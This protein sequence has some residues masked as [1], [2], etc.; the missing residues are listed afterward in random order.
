[1]K[2]SKLLAMGTMAL[3]VASLASAATNIKITGSTAFRTATIAAIIDSL[4]TT[5]HTVTGGYDV[6]AK[7]IAGS[8]REIIHGFL[9]STGAEV[10]VQCA[11]AG[12]VGGV[13]VLTQD[14][15]IPP[16]SGWSNSTTW[17]STSNT[18]STVT[19]GTSPAGGADLSSS[20]V[21]ETSAST[22][23][24]S[25]SDSFQASTVYTTPS[26][27]DRIVGVV[28]F[29]WAKSAGSVDVPTASYNRL[30]NITPLQAQALLTN[31]AVPLSFLTG[32]SADDA[33]DVVVT[34]R[35]NDSGTRLTAFAE[36]GFG[37]GSSPVQ[38][39]ISA[40][41]GTIGAV[42]PAASGYASGG[43]VK[44]LLQATVATGKKSPN[45]L[46]YIVVAYLGKADSPGTGQELKWNGASYGAGN[47]QEGAYTFWGYEHLLYRSS[48]TDTV[49]LQ[50]IDDVLA[51]LQAGDALAAGLPYDG[52]AGTTAGQLRVGRTNDGGAIYSNLR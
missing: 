25:M 44:S 42:F 48:L 37:I 40:T 14:L 20:G 30:T 15:T 4:D 46:P 22:A 34:G 29:V 45:G 51:Q 19:G 10:Y 39:N 13:Q 47:I 28:G 32:N 12:S 33:Y 9:K 41:D 50:T 23:D 16:G 43:N 7:G 11:W 6:T 49:A 1:M 24:I 5:T 27:E 38:Y 2:S 36:S 3:A 21:Y 8:N 31:G 52:G 35:N 26:L 17:L 18:L